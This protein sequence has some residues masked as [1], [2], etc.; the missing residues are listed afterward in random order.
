MNFHKVISEILRIPR[1]F[2]LLGNVSVH[3]L[4][5]E[6]GYIDMHSLVSV[7]EIRAALVSE[8]ECVGEWLA[9]SEDKRC[10][11]GW[12]F[13]MTETH[14]YAVGYYPSGK[15]SYTTYDDPI[16]ACAA[17][18]GKEIEDVRQCDEKTEGL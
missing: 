16:D 7:G 14:K 3:T 1:N 13:T 18:I 10:K 11:S 6:S 17:F 2:R 15:E 12:Y 4:L 8:P 9:Y 5:K